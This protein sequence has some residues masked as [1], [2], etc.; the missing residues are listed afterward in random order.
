MKI[1]LTL[2][3]LGDATK[4]TKQLLN[5]PVFFDSAFYNGLGFVPGL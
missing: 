2:L 5:L 4:E 1:K 3:D